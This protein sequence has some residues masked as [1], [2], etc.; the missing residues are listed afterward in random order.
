MRIKASKSDR[1]YICGIKVSEDEIKKL[2][3]LTADFRPEWNYWLRSLK[4]QDN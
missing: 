1:E 3:I 4:C 2:R